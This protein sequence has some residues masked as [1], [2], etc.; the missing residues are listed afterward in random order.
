[1]I[2]DPAATGGRIAGRRWLLAR[3]KSFRHAVSGLA[4]ILRTQPNAKVHLAI[5]M[6]VVATAWRLRVSPDDWRWLAISI[7]LVW[8]AEALNTSIEYV[9]DVVSPQFHP[10]VK[11]AKDIGAAAVLICAGGAVA[12]GAITLW[13]YLAS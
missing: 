8:A 4:F 5:A 6:L 3:I 7:V 11:R 10:L 12:L 1:M 13:P 2:P 9:C